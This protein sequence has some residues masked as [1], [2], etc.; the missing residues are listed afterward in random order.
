MEYLGHV[1]VLEGRLGV[2]LGFG[3]GRLQVVNLVRVQ[4]FVHL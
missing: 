3:D 4:E 1:D 2:L